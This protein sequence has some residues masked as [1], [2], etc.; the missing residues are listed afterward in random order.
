LSRGGAEGPRF[1]L[2]HSSVSVQF[3][4]SIYRILL[5]QFNSAHSTFSVRLSERSFFISMHVPPN[6]PV[7][8]TLQHM[9]FGS[10]QV[11]RQSVQRIRLSTIDTL[12]QGS[13]IPILKAV[14]V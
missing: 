4:A 3:I 7:F 10:I 9:V 8:I 12:I 2:A 13:V 14:D 1:Y 11:A 6:F 5:L